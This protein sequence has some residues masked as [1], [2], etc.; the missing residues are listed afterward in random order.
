MAEPAGLMVTE[1]MSPPSAVIA[2]PRATDLAVPYRFWSEK[3]SASFMFCA[4]APAARMQVNSM[5]KRVFF[6]AVLFTKL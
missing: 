5:E 1:P 4:Q 6:M 2:F 3:S